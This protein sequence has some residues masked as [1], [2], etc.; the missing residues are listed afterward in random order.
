MKRDTYIEEIDK[1][2]ITR[3]VDK[4]TGELLQH[5]SRDETEMML[6]MCENVRKGS[7]PFYHNGW[8]QTN[9]NTSNLQLS[10]ISRISMTY[11]GKFSH[12]YGESLC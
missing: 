11:T 6:R 2:G 1:H 8:K 3:L 9:Y 12:N 7:K 4:S 10:T 5:K